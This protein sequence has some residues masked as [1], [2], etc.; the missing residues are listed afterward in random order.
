MKKYLVGICSYNEGEKIKRVVRKFSDYERYDVL[1]VDDGSTDGSIDRLS[2]NPSL[3][4]IHNAATRG[5][6]Y[7][8]RQIIAYGKEKGYLAAIFVAGNDKDS[9]E[10][11]G[12]LINAV[13]DGYDFIQGSRYLKGAHYGKMPFYRIMATRFLHPVL[14]SLITGKWISDS[15]NG[16]RAVRLSLTADPRM[17]LNQKWLDAYELEPYLFYQAVRLGYKVKEVPVT[18]IYPPA[19]EGY[20][21]MKPWSGWWSILRPLV[22]LGLHIKK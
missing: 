17:D 12:K 11:V 8:T 7:G 14:F 10:D 20:T 16:F 22:Y 13:E 18:K 15:T 9:A 2:Q 5:A 4:I 6:G 1:I 19:S 3:Y 21:K